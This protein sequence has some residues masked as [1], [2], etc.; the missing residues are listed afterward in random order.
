MSYV[1]VG[2]GIVG[3][4]VARALLLSRPG[5]AVTVLDKEPTVAAHQT[6]HN[7]G[8]VHA[9]LYYPPGSL[10]AVL[11]RRGVGLLEEYTAD[12][13][14]PY[15]KLGKLLVALDRDEES[16]LLGIR[17]RALANGVPDIRML[18]PDGLRAIEPHATGRAALHSPHTAVVD[19]PRVARSLA[20][21]ITALGG[22]VLLGR[23]VRA[24][25]QSAGAVRVSTGAEHVVAD[26]AVLCGG[27][28]ADRL[29]RLA[30]GAPGPRI[31]P[32]RGE[33]YRLTPQRASLVRGLIYPVPDPRYPFLGV[34]LTRRHDGSVDVGPN[35]L[36]ALAREGYRHRDV[37]LRDLRESLAW[38][39]LWQL[40]RR[41]WRTGAR[42]LAGS[43]VKRRFVAAARAY[44][45]ELD[46]ADLRRAPAGVRAQ[47]LDRDGALVDDFRIET[48]DRVVAVRN[49]PS[50]A[51][52]SA[53]AIAEHVVGR[54]LTGRI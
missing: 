15:Q 50:P 8:V 19:F 20:E 33:Y 13:G 51:A 36:L 46:P 10:K 16:R 43:V 37:D 38:P 54:M 7:S 31:V 29:A 49:A 12:K 53:L 17:E 21:D 5:S 27:L 39:G 4:S 40:G 23:T 3:L 35:A 24:I 47:A 11:C 9:G 2:A 45:P 30:G 18:G 42:E 32:F 6:G 44:V 41:H 1:V 14:I 52:T 25:N 48:V 28:H 22:Q 34:H 26:Q